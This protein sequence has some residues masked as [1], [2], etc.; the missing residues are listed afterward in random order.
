MRFCCNVLRNLGV[1]GIAMIFVGNKLSFK[2]NLYFMRYMHANTT[3]K[4]RKLRILYFFTILFF[5]KFFN[6]LIKFLNIVSLDLS[7]KLHSFYKKKLQSLN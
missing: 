6:F 4:S 2:L 3:N 7:Q 1:I 5:L